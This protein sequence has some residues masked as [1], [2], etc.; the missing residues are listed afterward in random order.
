L[1]N[2]V[3]T[4]ASDP[5]Q[6]KNFSA[7]GILFDYKDPFA[8]NSTVEIEFLKPNSFDFFRTKARIVR[9]EINPDNKTYDIGVEFVEMSE[10]EK[11]QL[12]YFISQISV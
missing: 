9:V 4:K 3:S 8:I 1:V 7:S 5:T 12:D 10:E 2:K 6:A 11:S